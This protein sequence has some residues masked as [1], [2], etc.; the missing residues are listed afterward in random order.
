MVVPIYPVCT[1]FRLQQRL[2]RTLKVR[3]PYPTTKPAGKYY[4]TLYK[5][6]APRACLHVLALQLAAKTAVLLLV[7]T[8]AFLLPF[9]HQVSWRHRNELA[10]DPS[11]TRRRHAYISTSTGTGTRVIS[12]SSWCSSSEASAGTSTNE[13]L[14][15]AYAH[16]FW[17]PA[18]E[19]V[20]GIP[21][22][23]FAGGAS[24]G[25]LERSRLCDVSYLCVL[26]WC[27]IP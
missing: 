23:R 12:S 1:Q 25:R 19:A 6:P 3:L 2:S 20:S 13:S 27:Y 14:D 9:P 22:R 8:R 11:A 16:G 21:S 10:R 15:L 24:E 18:E 5:M 26:Y 7:E 4:C 17:T